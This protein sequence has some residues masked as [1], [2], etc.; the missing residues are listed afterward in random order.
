[1]IVAVDSQEIDYNVNLLLEL[2]DEV[3]QNREYK[4]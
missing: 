1:M 4:W 3:L 2:V